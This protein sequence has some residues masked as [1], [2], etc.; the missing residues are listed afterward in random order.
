MKLRSVR[1]SRY[2]NLRDCAIEFVDGEWMNC[3]IGS[4]GSGK[5]NLIEAI[6]LIMLGTYFKSPPKFNYRLAFSVQG[7]DVV[8]EQVRRR[9]EILVDGSSMPLGLIAE[10]LR[11]GTS[12]VFFP[13]LTFIYYSGTC[14]RVRRFIRKYERHFQRLTR[15][16]ELDRLRPLFVESST[17]HADIALLALFAHGH[18]PLLERLR[19]AQV[20]DIELVLHSPDDYDSE[21][22]EP[23]LWNTVGAVRRIVAAIDETCE[24]VG[25]GPA[26]TS[27][28]QRNPEITKVRVQRVYNIGMRGKADQLSALASRLNKANDNL[29]LALDQLR[30]RRILHKVRFKIRSDVSGQYFDIDD[31]S[32][33]EKQLL[34]VVG[35]LALNTQ[36]DNLVLLDEPDTHLNP[37]W[38]WEFSDLL[39]SA[40][41]SHRR[42]RSTVLIATHSPVMISG[43]KKEQ[44]LLA[45]DEEELGTTLRRPM[46]SPK[47]Q[48]I[49]NLI[50]SSEF[51]GLPSSLDKETQKLMDE[52]LKLAMK[53]ELSSNDKGRLAQLNNQLEFISSGVSERDPDY[54]EFLRS[55]YGSGKEG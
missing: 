23:K 14:E 22:H 13:E 34:S 19:L 39:K 52:R 31:L 24:L 55:K 42:E 41:D 51:F 54:V 36:P 32:E 30:S 45:N 5:S 21:R 46:R 18:S 12:Q 4:N 50:C 11:E 27:R 53:A 2:K 48:G 33:G 49:A 29:Y 40:M 7:R 38:T 17:K 35:V 1:I 16:P 25:D 44:V 43:L 3:I 26:P 8:L 15:A 10:R 28:W 47:G 20:S 9:P 6:L 37:Q